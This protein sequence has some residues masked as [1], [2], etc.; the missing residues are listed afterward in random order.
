M[1]THYVMLRLFLILALCAL[2][3]WP[4]QNQAD[5]TQM[6]PLA[7]GNSWEYKNSV[8]YGMMGLGPEFSVTVSIT[9][10]EDIF[11]RLYYIFSDLPVYDPPMEYVSEYGFVLPWESPP[12]PF[13]F[14]AGKKVRWSEDG[15]DLLFLTEWPGDIEVFRF[16]GNYKVRKIYDLFPHVIGRIFDPSDGWIHTSDGSPPPAGY[17]DHDVDVRFDLLGEEGLPVVQFRFPSR[18]VFQSG[19]VHE[20]DVSA[21]F[22]KGLG[23]FA[24]SGEYFF[25]NCGPHLNSYAP[26]AD[27]GFGSDAGPSTIDL[28]LDSAV[29]GGVQWEGD[30]IPTSSRPTVVHET[31]WG[32]VKHDTTRSNP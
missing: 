31:S 19:G 15:Q 21:S 16:D 14:F 9:H 30:P 27:C 6:M 12:V 20:R 26:N 7:V 10:T 13:F 5:M 4:D 24:A 8:D 25:T 2:L 18:W 17:P 1:E 32:T 3:V 28:R 11:G 23:L 29:I 22:A